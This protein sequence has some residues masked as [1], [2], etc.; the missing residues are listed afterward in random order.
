M[1][2]TTTLT[3]TEDQ[4]LVLLNCVEEKFIDFM[5]AKEQAEYDKMYTRLANALRRIT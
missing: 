4:L 1:K 5:P 3:F 2:N